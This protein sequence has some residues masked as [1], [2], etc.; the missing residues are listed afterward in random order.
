LFRMFLM[1]FWCLPALASSRIVVTT[2]EPVQLFVDGMLIP[3]SIGNIRSAI[4][5]IAPGSHVVAIHDLL[6]NLQHKE[7]V[8]VPE[9]ADVRVNW[10][11][12][13]QFQITG[14]DPEGAA[15][16]V[17]DGTS[18]PPM[19]E[20]PTNAPAYT[21][22]RNEGSV[23]ALR[24][25]AS[26]APS[27]GTVASI[28]TGSGVAGLAAGAAASGVRSLTYGAKA[29]VSFGEPVAVPQRIIRPNVVYGQVRFI[30][31]GGGP[32]VVYEN[33]MIV[34]RL[35]QGEVELDLSIEVGRRELEIRSDLD[36]RV[37]FQGDLQVDRGHHIQLA[38]SESVPPRATQ[39]PWL[40]KSAD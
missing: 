2:T 30:K 6:G 9:G 28:V 18:G 16:P 17:A 25:S 32:I 22:P 3:T 39:R 12:G 27:V 40:Y 24:A 35:E 21:Q 15:P 10:T 34:A 14:T 23:Q 7:T 37:L 33:G 31:S 8:M 36:N 20:P 4:P 26:R 19:T 5:H 29:G 1:L 38:V 13:G 11:P